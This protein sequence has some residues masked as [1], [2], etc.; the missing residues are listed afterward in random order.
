MGS[1]ERSPDDPAFIEIA[2]LPMPADSA[3]LLCSDGL[4]DLITRAEI[5][6]CMERYAPDYDTAIAP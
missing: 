1:S 5:R 2:S 4:T 6:A 3:M